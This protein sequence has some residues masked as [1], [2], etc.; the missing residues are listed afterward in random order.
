MQRWLLTRQVSLGA[1]RVLA[2]CQVTVVYCK[3]R[4]GYRWS[5]EN[6]AYHGKN[7]PSDDA[8]R[9]ARFAV[10]TPRQSA[11]HYG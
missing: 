9:T 1:M 2:H 11:D 3:L 7:L 6:A 5:N 10:Q 4:A 8:A